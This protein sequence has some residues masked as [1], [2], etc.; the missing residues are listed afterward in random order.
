MSEIYLTEQFFW[1]VLIAGV[2]VNI[3][4]EIV[5]R[6]FSRGYFLVSARLRKLYALNLIRREKEINYLSTSTT[7]MIFMQIKSNRLMTSALLMIMFAFLAVI[8]TSTVVTGYKVILFK[9]VAIIALLSGLSS[10]FQFVLLQTK[11][12]EAE[13]KIK[14]RADLYD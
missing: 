10:F 7:Q 4:T 13:L 8:I 3:F 14:T 11:I 5:K 6:L 9:V 1:G 2:F 12:S